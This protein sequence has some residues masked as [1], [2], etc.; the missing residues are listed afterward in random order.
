MAD[1]TS[2][3]K[4]IP[5]NHIQFEKLDS[6]YTLLEQV[7]EGKPVCIN[8]LYYLNFR[9]GAGRIN[10]Y[11]DKRTISQIKSTGAYALIKNKTC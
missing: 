6:L 5:I 10:F 7:A 8:W 11:A 9:Y 3:N 2:L 4:V 1:T